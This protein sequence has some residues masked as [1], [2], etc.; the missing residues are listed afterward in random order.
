MDEEAVAAT[1]QAW[2]NAHKALAKGGGGND[3]RPSLSQW[4]DLVTEL[5]RSEP[6]ALTARLDPTTAGGNSWK[7]K[8]AKAILQKLDDGAL[9]PAQRAL[10]ARLFVRWLRA[11]MREGAR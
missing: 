6:T 8:D 1:T 3:R 11:A 10:H 9:R 5:E 4:L 2:Y 7:H